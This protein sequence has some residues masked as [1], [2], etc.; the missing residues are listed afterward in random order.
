MELLKYVQ[1][2]EA[3]VLLEMEDRLR[4]VMNYIIGLSDYMYFTPVEMKQNSI[5]FL[6]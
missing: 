2:V 5:T 6:W 4:V 3:V 1:N